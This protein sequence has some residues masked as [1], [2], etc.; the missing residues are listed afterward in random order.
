MPRVDLSVFARGIV[1]RDAQQREPLERV[2][3]EAR[4][5]VDDAGG[6]EPREMANLLGDQ[7]NSVSLRLAAAIAGLP[8][9]WD[10]RNWFAPSKG[11]PNSFLGL[12]LSICRAGRSEEQSCSTRTSWLP[13]AGRRFGTSTRSPSPGEI[14]ARFARSG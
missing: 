11:N 1:P 4:T 13:G 8:T 7:G 6:C 5:F 12:K 3:A 14:K 10:A 9:R 2:A